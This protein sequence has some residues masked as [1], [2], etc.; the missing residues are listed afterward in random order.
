MKKIIA[1]LFFIS[2]SAVMLGGCT[3]TEVG[4][5]VGGAAGAGLGYAVTGGSAV[6]TVIGA[7]A[8]ALVGN[9]IGRDQDRRQYYNNRYYRHGHNYYY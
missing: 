5:G 8:G 6:G 3:N 4:T 9:A 7:G 2:L 1:P